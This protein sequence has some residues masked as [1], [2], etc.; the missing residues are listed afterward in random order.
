MKTHQDQDNA[1]KVVQ[2]KAEKQES[3]FKDE[4]SETVVQTKLY[5][6]VNLSPQVTQ[7]QSLQRM[8]DNRVQNSPF[9]II[10]K[11]EN[12]TGLPD[13]LKSGIEN[14]SGYGM[15]D[16]KVHYNSPKPAQLQAH[17]YAQGT[18][19]HL[20][21]GQEKHLPHEAWHVVQQ[22]QGRVKPTMQMKGKV[23]VNDDSGL[24][25][26]ADVM[27]AK[28]VLMKKNEQQNDLKSKSTRGIIQRYS[29]LDSRGYDNWS[30]EED[31]MFP[32]QQLNTS[33]TDTMIESVNPIG[34]T[35]NLNPKTT[36][37]AKWNQILKNQPSLKVSENSNLAIE[38]SDDQPKAFYATVAIIEASNKRLKDIGSRI[39]FIQNT[40]RNFEV[41]ADMNAPG[42]GLTTE[43]S[44]V[45]PIKASH[46]AE[47]EQLMDTNECNNVANRIVGGAVIVVGKESNNT[48]EMLEKFDFG[49][50]GTRITTALHNLNNGDDTGDLSN[51]FALTNNFIMPDAVAANIQVRFQPLIDKNKVHNRNLKWLSLPNMPAY[52][53]N[54]VFNTYNTA[55]VLG[56]VNE[57]TIEEHIQTQAHLQGSENYE[58]DKVNKQQ[59]IQDLSINEYTTPEVGEAFST[60]GSGKEIQI[61]DNNGVMSGVMDL[62]SLD[63]IQKGY[64]LMVMKQAGEQLNVL[65]VQYFNDVRDQ[66]H[67]QEHHAAVVAKDGSDSITFENYNRSVEKNFLF[68]KQWEALGEKFKF[69]ADEIAQ[70]IET[71]ATDNTKNALIKYIEIRTKKVR[72]LQ[73]LNNDLGTLVKNTYIAFQKNS[74]SEYNDLW[75]FNMYGTDDGQS[76]HEKWAASH[77][78]PVTVRTSANVDAEKV[79]RFRR[80]IAMKLQIKGLD[81]GSPNVVGT[82]IPT[83]YADL[84]TATTRV[85]SSKLYRN[86]LDLIQSL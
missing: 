13:N 69:F 20:A 48:S 22:K 18:D 32:S 6:M 33:I 57:Y 14:L 16:V 49:N 86:A 50:S 55:A 64:A 46:I 40:S 74:S 67:F 17:A 73:G 51:Q 82:Q 11:K 61:L 60:V 3:G 7:M 28:A 29:I 65:R 68:I 52:V 23:N 42:N 77:G 41:P 75:H 10:Q 83:L 35:R 84:L 59:L 62:S 21:S 36:V 44:M 30:A 80:E 1:P 53:I 58:Q 8:A 71:I 81:F 76:F 37:R 39:Q 9:D 15:D 34:N 78:N 27:G 24:E 54:Q 56:D 45:T 26:E 66:A 38:H 4:R 12:K 63:T 2:Q 5:D 19:I 31:E 72:Q 85:E 43:V 25:R 47:G 79:Q 70:E